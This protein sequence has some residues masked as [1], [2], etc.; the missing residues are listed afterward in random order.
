MRPEWALGVRDRC[1]AA[2]AAFLFKQWDAW[3]PDGVRR[4][5]QANGRVL[6]GRLWDERPEI[7]GALL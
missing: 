6:A 2:G 3:G 1:R 4:D 5:K 7:A